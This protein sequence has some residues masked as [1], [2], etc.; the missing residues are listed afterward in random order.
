MEG[1]SKYITSRQ[2]RHIYTNKT[3]KAPKSIKVLITTNVSMIKTGNG[4]FKF[5][6]STGQETDFDSQLTIS[7]LTQ[8]DNWP[9]GH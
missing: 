6:S 2:R 4:G 8:Y 3:V 7:E 1:L 5:C 9:A